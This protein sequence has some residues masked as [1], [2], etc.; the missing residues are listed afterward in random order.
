MTFGSLLIKRVGDASAKAVEE[1][2]RG[3]SVKDCESGKT[4]RAA[5]KR[6]AES[7]HKRIGIICRRMHNKKKQKV[8]MHLGCAFERAYDFRCPEAR[9]KRSD[10]ADLLI[11]VAIITAFIAFG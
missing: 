11:L 3:W 2:N 6:R 10:A 4:G 9:S 7:C 1:K 8:P 5:P